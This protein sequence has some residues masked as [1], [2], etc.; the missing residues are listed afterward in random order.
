DGVSSAQF[1]VRP[2]FGA[3]PAG[4]RA[5]EDG[6]V[7]DTRAAGST[8]GSEF[9]GALAVE[10][11]SDTATRAASLNAPLT[12]C[13][14]ANV[15]DQG[16][17]SAQELTLLDCANQ[18]ISSLDGIEDLVALQTLMLNDNPLLDLAP[19]ALLPNLVQLDLARTRIGRID[20]LQNLIHLRIV[21]VSGNA[22]TR[23]TPLANLNQLEELYAANNQIAAIPDLSATSLSTLALDSNPL[24]D[25]SGLAAV[26]TLQSARLNATQV[27]DL[28]PLILNSQQL[29]S[30]LRGVDLLGVPDLY[31]PQ[32]D[33]LAAEIGIYDPNASGVTLDGVKP[34]ASCNNIPTITALDVSSNPSIGPSFQ[35]TWTLDGGAADASGYSFKV[36]RVDDQHRSVAEHETRRGETVYS[37]QD[38]LNIGEHA[39]KV[40][41]CAAEVAGALCGGW[42]PFI[43]V[44]VLADPGI[45]AADA[46]ANIADPDL[47]SCIDA[48]IDASMLAGELTQ[49]SC[50]SK[51]IQTTAG[52]EFFPNLS[53]IN[54]N[55]NQIDDLSGIHHLGALQHLELAD[56][57][58]ASAHLG[59]IASAGTGAYSILN[60]G[61]NGAG[62]DDLSALSALQRIDTLGLWG[63]RISDLSPIEQIDITT[64]HAWNNQ[65]AAI[66]YFQ[67][68]RVL[69]ASDNQIA[70]LTGLCAPAGDPA[71]PPT[72]S[73]SETLTHLELDG[74]PLHQDPN[75]SASLGEL[76]NLTYASLGS[77]GLT[78]I[79]FASNWN[80]IEHFN[81]AGNGSI[82]SLSALTGKPLEWLDVSGTSITDFSA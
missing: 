28:H 2:V 69:A 22:I 80:L 81:I 79:T 18:G 59:A 29:N 36:R 66:P 21:D 46:L 61:G 58:I 43:T 11:G 16:M 52:I 64:L 49:L 26:D 30:P 48:N 51:G 47:W 67:G 77:T 50:I 63:N 6:P 25:L 44:T 14:N 5:A 4:T 76:D 13:I 72:G 75:A 82:S 31:C 10:F 34:P 41:A 74:N 32:I 42:S 71:C 1:H 23:L 20:A 57:A 55:S 12:T 17:A 39:F 40:Q 15:K 54:F 35:L 9:S 62:L 68:L 19:L 65:I 24:I 37:N 45:P 33:Q 7:A 60:L 78:E 73:M 3:A 38:P 53:R 56:N 27:G 8:G 70:A